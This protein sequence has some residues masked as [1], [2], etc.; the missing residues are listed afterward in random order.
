MNAVLFIGIGLLIGLLIG[1][2]SAAKQDAEMKAAHNRAAEIKQR[3]EFVTGDGERRLNAVYG[4]LD[5]AAKGMD[6]V[7]AMF[8]YIENVNELLTRMSESDL[9]K[10]DLP[11]GA[12][13][14]TG[15]TQLVGQNMEAIVKLNEAGLRLALGMHYLR[16]T[17]A[18]LAPSTKFAAEILQQQSDLIMEYAPVLQMP[19][20]KEKFAEVLA[21]N[22][23]RISAAYQNGETPPDGG[24][25]RLILQAL[26]E[27]YA[28]HQVRTER[29][30]TPVP[31]E[32]HDATTDQFKPPPTRTQVVHASKTRYERR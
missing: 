8:P 4:Q 25:V 2:I 15:M 29:L 28:T 11:F 7:L 26:D 9:A 21:M 12:E 31:T 23:N 14:Q 5:Q 1:R 19:G 17:G 20:I 10:L 24:Q 6:K 32:T 27:A 13:F 16:M 3:L 30:V 18:A 22:L